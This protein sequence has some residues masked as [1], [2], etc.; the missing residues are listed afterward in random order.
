MKSADSDNHRACHR[1][2]PSNSRCPL[3]GG[4]RR[5]HG[6]RIRR[7][8]PDDLRKQRTGNLPGENDDCGRR[9]LHA[10]LVDLVLF[11]IP[12]G[13]LADGGRRQTGCPTDRTVADIGG[14]SGCHPGFSG[15]GRTANNEIGHK[16]GRP[17]GSGDSILT[18]RFETGKSPASSALIA[19]W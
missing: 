1:M 8:Q 11:G 16:P 6:R 5:E 17:K 4:E 18:K 7:V 14:A 13:K 3:A 2:Y 10:D 12:Q 15:A 19:A 9:D